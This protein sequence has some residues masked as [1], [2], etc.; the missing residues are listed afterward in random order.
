MPGLDD[1]ENQVNEHDDQIDQGLD[2][3]GDAAKDKVGHDD[4]IDSALGKAEN[5]TGDNN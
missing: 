5:A 1:L 3:A 2:K 4:Q